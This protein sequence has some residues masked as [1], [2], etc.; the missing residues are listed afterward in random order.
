MNKYTY[1]KDTRNGVLFRVLNDDDI[2]A[3]YKVNLS[4]WVPIPKIKIPRRC[5]RLNEIDLIL[6]DIVESE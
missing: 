4:P 3:E 2:M 5:V 6:H 1:Y